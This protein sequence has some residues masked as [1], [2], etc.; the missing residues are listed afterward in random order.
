M[1]PEGMPSGG[2]MYI[3]IAI[4]ITILDQITKWLVDT[5]LSYNYEV[6]VIK[7]FFYITYVKN[8]GA[9]WGIL[10]NGR[11][12]FVLITILVVIGILYFIAKE[13]SGYKKLVLSFILGGALGNFIDRLFRGYVIDFLD[14]YIFSYNFPTFNIADIFITIGTIALIC[15]IIFEGN[16]VM[17]KEI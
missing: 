17:K 4:A 15:V 11:I 8:K 5:S 10:Q 16:F 1:H 7:N 13:K 12:F 6:E 2:R 3:L 9:V 14:F